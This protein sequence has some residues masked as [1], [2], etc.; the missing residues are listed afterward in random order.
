M[1][2]G[3]IDSDGYSTIEHF[4]ICFK[5]TDF[6]R[7]HHNV[8][9]S[10]LSVRMIGEM[11]SAI[12]IGAPAL[13]D[14]TESDGLPIMLTNAARFCFTIDNDGENVSVKNYRKQKSATA[15]VLTYDALKGSIFSDFIA[16]LERT[17]F[18]RN[19][20][21]IIGNDWENPQNY[22]GND[23]EAVK[24]VRSKINGEAWRSMLEMYGVNDV[25]IDM[26]HYDQFGLQRLQ[27]HPLF[28]LLQLICWNEEGTVSPPHVFKDFKVFFTFYDVEFLARMLAILLTCALYPKKVLPVLQAIDVTSSEKKF[29]N[30]FTDTIETVR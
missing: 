9:F 24:L 23:R 8:P 6:G 7:L 4:P 3:V 2:V 20:K 15:D 13:N 12:G 10:Q 14:A 30:L 18:Y 26:Y 28:W 5:P 17:D 25:T 22:D 11:V 16:L 27:K 1:N 21:R 19:F 29:L